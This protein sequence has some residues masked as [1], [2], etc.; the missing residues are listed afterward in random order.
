MNIL[1][2]IYDTCDKMD[3]KKIKQ[4]KKGNYK[5]KGKRIERPSFE[6]NQVFYGV[7]VENERPDKIQEIENV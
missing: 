5:H 4:L 1:E 3:E 2:L 6:R 7:L